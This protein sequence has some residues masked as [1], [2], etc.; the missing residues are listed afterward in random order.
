MRSLIRRHPYSEFDIVRRQLDQLFNEI[1]QVSLDSRFVNARATTPQWIPAVEIKEIE[2]AFMLRAAVPG[3]DAKDLDVQ[4]SRDA[5]VIKGE[6][7]TEAKAEAHSHFSSEFRYGKFHR[8]IPLRTPI[9]NDQV[10]ADLKDGIL[11][12]TLPKANLA[13]AVVKLN[14]TPTDSTP[15]PTVTPEPT[16]NEPTIELTPV[17]T[18]TPDPEL[19]TDIWAEDTAQ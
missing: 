1:A 8:V 19:T 12:L 17:A 14:L 5:V 2:N 15:A 10:E 3:V 13:P 11:T 9:Q 6:Y 4:V 7:R 18:S 16:I